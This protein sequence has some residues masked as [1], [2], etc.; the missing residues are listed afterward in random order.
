MR[1]AFY[2]AFCLLLAVGTGCALTDYP[3]ITDKDG[4][5]PLPGHIVNT[6]GKAH[7]KEF[8]I[9][10]ALDTGQGWFSNHWF[11]DQ[12]SNGDHTSIR[13]QLT[14]PYADSQLAFVDEKYCTPDFISCSAWTATDPPGGGPGFPFASCAYDG[15]GNPQCDGFSSLL[16]VYCGQRYYG[17]CGR[18]NMTTGD[19][20]QIANTGR[21]GASMGMEGLL[22]DFNGRNLS[23]LIDNNAGYIANIPV[24]GSAVSFYSPKNRTGWM[25]ITNPLLGSTGR[26][27]ADFLANHGTNGMTATMIYNGIG[28]TLRFKDVGGAAKVLRSVNKSF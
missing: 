13:T 20:L 27:Y 2:A 28:K 12:K 18:D 6:N 11:V 10:Y 21:L 1:K 14:G 7:V 8:T 9:L 4:G 15:S 16:F 26:S 3:I 23:L 19:M 24:R 25:D 17:E 22:F 5:E